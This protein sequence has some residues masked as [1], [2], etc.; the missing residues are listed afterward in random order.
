[1]VVADNKVT[2]KV[3]TWY[4][5]NNL[6]NLSL[7]QLGPKWTPYKVRRLSD[8]TIFKLWDR[9]NYKNTAFSINFAIAEFRKGSYLKNEMFAYTSGDTGY[10]LD[11][12]EK[13]L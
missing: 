4:N 10:D 7:R 6:S 12:L 13:T 2:Y 11:H 5:G 9:V 3:I 1:M 8:N